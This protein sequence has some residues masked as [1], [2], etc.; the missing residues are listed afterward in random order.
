MMPLWAVIFIAAAGILLGLKLLYAASIAGLLPVTRGALFVSTG[1]PR[2]KEFLDAV[3][4]K[5]GHCPIDLGC[6]DGRVLR[7]AV[8]RYG[9]KA[10]GFEINPM[11]YL[12]ARI[13]CAGRK[14]VRVRYGN[15]WNMDLSGGDVVFCY[16]FPDLMERLGGKLMAELHEGSRVVSC[17]FSLPGWKPIC[18][19]RPV[20]VRHG[21]PI[22][23]YQIPDS[24]PSPDATSEPRPRPA[25]SQRILSRSDHGRT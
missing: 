22:Y 8:R 20:S 14:G 15:F 3:P 2:I 7:A 19:R 17:N 4:M 16:L 5:P 18:I 13:L 9:V 24:L 25:L 6:G 11:A 1:L 10:L 21:D 12:A 23:I